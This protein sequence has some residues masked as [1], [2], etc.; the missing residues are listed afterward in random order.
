MKAVKNFLIETVVLTAAVIG[1]GVLKIIR[2]VQIGTNG[3][4]DDK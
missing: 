1:W 2:F 4:G 3:T